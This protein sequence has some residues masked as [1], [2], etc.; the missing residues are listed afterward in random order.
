MGYKSLIAGLVKD[1]FEILGTDSD[2]LATK[3]TYLSVSATGVYDP[4]TRTVTNVITTY[5]GVPMVLLKFAVTDAVEDVRPK[6]DRKVL[7]ASLN[8]AVTPRTADK[9]ELV[10]GEMYEVVKVLSDPSDSL[11]SLHVRYVE[12]N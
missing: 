4:V 1:S 2:G 9:I 3:Q 5:S 6:T 8:L 11:I 7:I 10:S 12:T